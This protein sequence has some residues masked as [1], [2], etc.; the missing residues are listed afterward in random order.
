MGIFD[1]FRRKQTPQNK[2]SVPEN[3]T[4]LEMTSQASRMPDAQ[5]RLQLVSDADEINK[6]DV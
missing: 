1:W 3:K 4:A 5:P 6:K 2:K